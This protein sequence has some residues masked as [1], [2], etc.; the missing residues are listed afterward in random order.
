[1][2]A[3]G[4]V[5]RAVRGRPQ[6]PPFK[7]RAAWTRRVI[8]LLE[9][10]Y[11][12]PGPSERK[13]PLSELIFTILSQHTSDVNRDRAWD[14]LWRSFASW[15]EIAA[16]PRARLERAIR[17][18]GL[19]PTKSAVIQK[20]LA[21]V[22][23]AE[24]SFSLDRLRGMGM[25]EVEEH[26]ASFPG[27]GLKTIRCV[28][29]FSLGLPAFPVDTHIY[30]VT[31]RLGLVRASATPAQVHAVMAE[32]TP[33][34]ETLPFHINLIT[35]GRKVCKA[36]RPLCFACVLRPE[37]RYGTRGP[38]ARLVSPALKA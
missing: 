11:G 24:G 16:A 18:G 32:L 33:P 36:L 4:T 38:G 1:V 12:R 28:Q 17:V 35:H 23:E 22:R 31:R 15:D 34:D 29:V 3:V 25:R 2:R 26:L 30:R 9:R 27:V 13:D 5:G 6:G 21:Q 8:A 14:S 10:A 37:C 7:D 20:V 19:A